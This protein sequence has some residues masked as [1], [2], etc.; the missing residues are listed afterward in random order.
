MSVLLRDVLTIPERA[1]AEDY[2]LRL[3]DSVGGNRVAQ[4]LAEYVVTESLADG[5]DQALGLVAEAIGSGVSRGAFLSGSFGSGKSHFMAVLYALLRGEPAA[6]QKVELQPVVAKHDPGLQGKKVLPL[7]FHLLG[8]ESMEK[9]LFDGYLRQI[10]ALHPGAPLPAIHQSDALLAD[11]ERQRGLL[12]DEQFF[13]GLNGGTAGDAGDDPWAAVLGS[14]TWNRET[15]DAARAAAPGEPKRQQLVTALVSTYFTSYTAQASYVD[16]DTGLSAISGHA[17]VLGYDAVVLF[18]DELVLWLAFSVQDR[19]FFRRESQKLT[20]LVESAVGGREIPLISFVARQMDLRQWFADA[21]ASGAQQDALDQAF[22]HQEGR[23]STIV[24]GDDN[25]PYVAHQRLLRPR[26]EAADRILRDAFG[27]LD[28]RGEVWD[29]LLDGVNTDER[30]R[31]AD[32]AAFR[33]TY[34][35]SPALVST[36]RSLASVMQRER[37]ALKVMQQLLVDRRN[38]LTVDDVIPVGD[39][40]DYV[41]EGREVLDPQVGALFRSATA[42][43]RDKLRPILLAEHGLTAEQVAG[44]TDLPA[45]YLADDRLAKSLLLSAVAPKVPALKELTASRL[46]SLNHG[47][48]VSPLPGAEVQIVLAK[49]KE[50]ARRVPEIHVSPDPRNPVIR[51]QL[52]DVDYESIVERAKSEDNEGRRRELLK[53][54]VRDAFGMP[55]RDTDVFGA[56]AHTVIWRGSRREVDVVFGNV[57]DAGWLTEDHFRAR[58]QTWRLVVDYP[59]DEH[60]HSAAEDLARV[61]Q[62]IAGGFQARTI[63]WLPRFLSE[64][65]LRDVRRL[66]ILEWLLGGA[67]ERWTSHADHLSEVDRVQAKAILEQQRTA[68]REGLRRSVQEAYGAAAPTPGT[69]LEDAAHDRVLISLDPALRVASPV[70]AD[71][72]AAFGNLVDQALTSQYPGHPR[73]EPADVEIGPRELSTTYGYVEKAV[74]DPDGRVLLER[75]DRDAVRRVANPLQVGSAGETHYL[76]GDDRFAAWGP[77]FARAMPRDGKQPQD[78][79]TVGD[80]RRWIEAMRPANG[81]RDEVAD[82]VILAWAALRQRAWYAHGAPLV[83]PPRPGQLRPEMELRPEPLPTPEEWEVAVRRA[84]ALFGVPASPFLTAPAV[85]ALTERVRSIAGDLSGFAAALIQQLGDAYGRLGLPDSSGRLA[86]AR[87][88]DSLLAQLRG[89]GDRVRLVQVLAG[90][91]DSAR[92]AALSRSLSSAPS[93][94]G[95]LSQYRWTLLQPLLDAEAT[96]PSATTALRGL[97]EALGHD[98]IVSGL[99]PVLRAAEEA[100]VTWLARHR[101]QPVPVPDPPRRPDDVP[102]PVPNARRVTRAKGESPQ[103]VLDE[104][105]AFLAEHPDER[106]VVEWRVEG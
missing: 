47:S 20:K 67:G 3:T 17:A 51:V 90:F 16:L 106:V 79:V 58:P 11:A 36:L 39:A 70:G 69:L 81:L 103:P 96:D 56:Q 64:E 49:V 62:L 105:S 72:A 77:E 87:E 37:T 53:D 14:G 82:L 40:F 74:A 76:F 52:S 19:A 29:V 84:A 21:G 31:G 6:R 46:A 65:R 26:D 13:A 33:L 43:Y 35:F 32:E 7:A 97:R 2:V 28:R 61:D 44:G 89:S 38:A 99:Q 59:F 41:V 9:A 55:A 92:D 95:A 57:R 88:A 75:S 23:F 15:Y 1:G 100:A 71:L 10:R 60:G 102:L 48:I 86:T 91:G 8:A 101:P 66:V 94:A 73:F 25:L 98:E 12:G 78:P 34:P 5:F 4:T 63:V 18:L 27:N 22:R 24:L 104:L 83:P 30:H 50:W 80:V 54:L 45:G 85:A 42:L 68:L 93:I